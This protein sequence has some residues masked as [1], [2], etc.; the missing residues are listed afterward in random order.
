MENFKD[1]LFNEK[2]E[3]QDK[4]H[5]LQLFTETD[6]YY[7]LPIEQQYLLTSQLGVMNAY[8]TILNARILLLDE[9]K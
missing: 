7:K 2:L 5:K 1:R 8:L 3:L 4:R 6:Q 9:E